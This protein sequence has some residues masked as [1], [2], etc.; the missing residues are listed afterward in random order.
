MNQIPQLPNLGN[1]SGDKIRLQIPNLN[2]TT[3]SS[4]NVRLPSLSDIS[5]SSGAGSFR[6]NPNSNQDDIFRSVNLALSLKTNRD[7]SK[8]EED[9][10]VISSHGGMV[11]ESKTEA[12]D[13]QPSGNYNKTKSTCFDSASAIH[14]IAPLP[15]MTTISNQVTQHVI[16]RIKTHQEPVIPIDM[17]TMQPALISTK[18]I[19][20]TTEKTTIQPISTP[21]VSIQPVPTSS[22]PVFIPPTSPQPVFTSTLP[23]SSQPVFIPPTSPQ[24]VFT[25]TL[26]ISSQPV[27]I[28]PT[29]PQSVI[30]VHIQTETV[31]FHP[32]LPVIGSEELNH[33]FTSFEKAE[34]M[35]G[36]TELAKPKY[37]KCSQD[38]PNNNSRVT[39]IRQLIDFD[40]SDPMA[41][42]LRSVPA[43]VDHFVGTSPM[44]DQLPQ[45]IPQSVS[46]P[47]EY[48]QSSSISPDP[49]CEVIHKIDEIPKVEKQ[50]N[51]LRL[52]VRP[53][54]IQKKTV[55]L[56]IRSKLKT[57]DIKDVVESRDEIDQSWTI[58]DIAKK[59]TPPGWVDLFRS[60][61][62]ELADI[63]AILADQENIYGIYFPLKQHIF[64]AFDMCPL[65]HVEVVII[66]QD[67]YHS[68][69]YNGF[70]T[71][72]GMSFSVSKNSPIPSSLGNIFKELARSVP[73]WKVPT[74][75]DL[76]NWAKQ[77]VLLLNTCLT[78]RQGKPKAHGDIWMGFISKVI[79]AISEV[80]PKCIYVLWGRPAERIERHLTGKNIVLKAPHPSGY[81]AHKGFIGCNHF[82]EVNKVLAEHG[83]SQIDWQT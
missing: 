19:P 36:R 60:A 43:L 56:V 64:R 11:K 12:D 69:D 73:G 31:S 44:V 52:V 42:M 59:A 82:M 14:G 40:Q 74:N 32:A 35:D 18:P 48:L 70:P 81:S 24:P 6:M 58:L 4:T 78:V 33:R 34:T 1:F 65:N 72:Q 66:G 77:G 23:I 50:V 16:E 39:E 8:S 21:L 13:D 17:S 76:S 79:Q 3:P 62:P 49:V 57:M 67:P 10:Y 47:I 71:A 80:N 51:Q 29:S 15:D 22:Q 30:P 46:T 75:G 68:T 37:L 28:P 63:Q 5:S 61:E 41:A 25:S 38:P 9:R 27:F 54:E 53:K 83:K 20:R 45:L 2:I 26:P 55:R 7:E